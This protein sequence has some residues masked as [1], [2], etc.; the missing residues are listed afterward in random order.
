MLVCKI[1]EFS[2][3]LEHG[4]TRPLTGLSVE[5]TSKCNFR[6]EHCFLANPLDNEHERNALSTDEWIRIFDQYVDEGGLFITVTGGEPLLRPDFKELWVAM[7]KRGLII[8]LFTNGSL[9]DEE[10]IEFLR[11]WTPYEVS[12]SLYGASEHTYQRVTGKHKMFKRVINTLDMF[13]DA[14]IPL[15]V[16]G[17]FSKLNI[18]DFHEV[19]AIGEKYCELFRWDVDLIGSFSYSGNMPQKIRLT[20]KE[21]AEFEAAEP[22]RNQEVKSAIDNWTPREKNYARSGSFTCGVGF[23][24]AYIDSEGG[25]RPCLPLESVSYDL[26]Y[27]TIKEGWYV[28]IPAMLNEFPHQPGPCQS[29]DAIEICGQCAAFA[30]LEGC[31]ATGSVPFK[32]KLAR[33]RANIYG[34][35][36]KLQ[37]LPEID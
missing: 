15:E 6:C 26:K 22:I 37:H 9:V 34:L 28:A 4:K 35:S 36:G 21:C 8:S 13:Q 33:E 17:V 14:G 3:K 20:P 11:H 23:Y 19:K 1:Q 16:K 30:L 27:G 25:L 24:T 7:K 10:M 29:C 2:S 18:S 12:I 5:F 31:S 32:C